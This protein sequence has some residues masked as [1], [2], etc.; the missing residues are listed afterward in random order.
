VYRPSTQ[1]FATVIS[2]AASMFGF[3]VHV[4]SDRPLTLAAIR[5]QARAI[6]PRA[7]VTGLDR[8]PDLVTVATRQP[9]LRMHLLVG[10]SFASLMLAAIGAYG[11]VS[12][13]VASRLREIAIRIAL[14]A[15]P[16]RVISS[17]TRG[18]LLTGIA[19]LAV[20][21]C[22]ALLLGRTLET[23]LYGVRSRDVSSFAVSGAALLLV[24]A[25]AAVI[26][27]FRA[28]RADPVKVLRAE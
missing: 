25:V 9:A 1:A 26:P 24:T 15:A 10:F 14:G 7:A 19:G 3:N 2:P 6:S 12:Q 13:A 28:V 17:M 18:V 23:L 22:A 21:M 16:S 20:G 4:R 27:A 5:E 11:V 8:V